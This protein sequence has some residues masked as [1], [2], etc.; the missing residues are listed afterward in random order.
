MQCWS[1]CYL[2]NYL[3]SSNLILFFICLFVLHSSYLYFVVFTPYHILSMY[4]Y[5]ITFRH[6][7]T[8]TGAITTYSVYNKLT[9]M[10]LCHS[11]FLILSKLDA[12]ISL[13]TLYKNSLLFYYGSFLR[14]SL[15]DFS[16]ILP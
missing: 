9:I 12:A 2:L 6:P 16:V 7:L 3:F 15:P 11:L 1:Y 10:T 8:K 13:G 5:Y 4:L 14:Y